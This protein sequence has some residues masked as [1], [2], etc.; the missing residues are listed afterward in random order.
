M[1]GAP[2]PLPP[3]PRR[4]LPEAGTEKELKEAFK[5]FLADHYSYDNES[6]LNDLNEQLLG[7]A[8]EHIIEIERFK[9][10]EQD[11]SACIFFYI[12]IQPR[13]TSND[14]L[15]SIDKARSNPNENVAKSHEARYKNIIDSFDSLNFSTRRGKR[16]LLENI[17]YD[18]SEAQK[19]V[20][21]F[22]WLTTDNSDA[23][24]WAWTY[25]RNYHER[26]IASAKANSTLD[27]SVLFR[28]IGIPK[29]VYLAPNNA[30]EQCLA[31]YAALQTWDCIPAELKQFRTNI[32]KAWRQQKDRK[33]ATTRPINT[34]IAIDS[35]EQL[36]ALSR[37]YKWS[38][39]KVLEVLIDDAHKKLTDKP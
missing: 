39:A 8:Q 16:D 32:A 4:H 29:L 33:S 25:L 34:R 15:F 7:L 17:E 2:Q 31:F 9:W 26:E 19:K 14:Y 5:L 1:R 35:K 30:Q 13:P 38:I 22:S 6:Y 21:P 3:R 11:K 24:H 18:Y 28:S 36:D 27:F 10:L 12:S 37:H 23:C 20:R